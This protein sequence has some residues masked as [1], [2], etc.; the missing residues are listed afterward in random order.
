[1]WILESDEIGHMAVDPRQH[2]ERDPRRP[3][4]PAV[5]AWV[6]SHMSYFVGLALIGI[7][8]AAALIAQSRRGPRDGGAEPRPGRLLLVGLAALAAS[9]LNPLGWRAIWQPFDFAL[10]WRNEP[11]FA[12]IGELQHL[13]LEALGWPGVPFLL[14]LWPLLIVWRAFRGRWDL[15]ELLTFAVFAGFAWS[16]VR[17]LGY[18]ALVGLPYLGRDLDAWVGAHR[19]PGWSAAPGGRAVLVSTVCVALVLPALSAT[20][21]GLSVGIDD[22]FV[23]EHAC[24]FMAAHRVRGRGF[25]HF[26]FG[27]YLLWR[28]WP[29]RER[30]PFA[31]IHP[32]AMRREDRLAYE[33]ARTDTAGWQALDRR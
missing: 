11:M 25:N 10:H 13:P 33:T 26:H 18:L 4:R 7:H 20:G 30:L 23:P 17:F 32:E 16:S 21:T 15:V 9:F 1:V 5:P 8:A 3:V 31:T 12:A 24:D 29:D 27:G 14:I 22:R 6:N 28:F 2:D 19:W